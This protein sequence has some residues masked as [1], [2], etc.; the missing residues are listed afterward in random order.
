M[1]EK[2]RLLG[3]FSVFYDFGVWRRICKTV[4]CVHV[5]WLGKWKLKEVRVKWKR[6]VEEKTRQTDWV[7]GGLRVIGIRGRIDPPGFGDSGHVWY[8]DDDI[9]KLS[10]CFP[11]FIVWSKT[12]N[13]QR[14]RTQSR[15]FYPNTKFTLFWTAANTLYQISNLFP[16][17]CQKS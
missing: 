15:L 13:L 8:L 7:R 4:V 3:T 1:K 2:V 16:R 11:I 10:F 17:F 5:L 9:R 14:D 12:A 6:Y